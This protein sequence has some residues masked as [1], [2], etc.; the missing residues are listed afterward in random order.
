MS[1]GSIPHLEE[2]NQHV[3]EHLYSLGVRDCALSERLARECVVE[4]CR[5]PGG[6]DKSQL[7]RRSIDEAQRRIDQ[8]LARLCADERSKGVPIE[9]LRAALH[10]DEF[11]TLSVD[12]IV[13]A[14]CL[15]PEMFER[16]ESILRR[17][18]PP[19]APL[20]ME[21]RSFSRGSTA[22]G[23]HECQGEAALPLQ[24]ASRGTT[25]LR[26]WVIFAFASG[27]TILA[28]VTVAR[29]MFAIGL[30]DTGLALL[31]IYTLLFST[32]A[33]SFWTAM[34]GLLVR[35]S[36]GDTKS[37]GRSLPRA[38]GK[39]ELS[40]FQ[41]RTALLM[42]IHNEDPIRVFAG[43]RAT[44]DSLR[45][46]GRSDEFEVFILS[47][48]QDSEIYA[49][50]E[51]HWHR[52]CR[53]FE[54]YGRIF[55][56]R[57][58]HNSGRKSGNVEEFCQ[59]WGGRYRYMV[60]MDADS[61]MSGACIT[62]LLDMIEAHPQVALIQ[63][64]PIAIGQK[65]LFARIIQF[66][67]SVLSPLYT[68]G[69]AWWFRGGSNY[70][71]HN[72][73]VRV[74]PFA[75]HCG[76]PRLPGREPLGGEIL[77]HDFVEAALLRNAGWEVWLVN[78]VAGSYEQVPPTLIDYVKR[79]R[80]WCQGNL[81]H[82]RVLLAQ[83]FASL[84]RL[85]LLMGIM[86]YVSSPLWLLFLFLGTMELSREVQLMVT[87]EEFQRASTDLRSMF[88]L[89]LAMLFLPRLGG[90]LNCY[91]DPSQMRSRGGYFRFTLS[92]FLEVLVAIAIAPVLMLY[93]C[94]FVCET[95][96]GRSV[97]W[98]GQAR[99]GHLTSLKKATAAHGLHTILGVVGAIVIYVYI[100]QVLWWTSPVLVGLVIS[101]V[102]SSV[103]S[104]E[105]LGKRARNLRLFLI[106][107]ETC[108]PRVIIHRRE[109]LAQLT[110][111]S[112]ATRPSVDSEF[113]DHSQT[114]RFVTGFSNATN[115]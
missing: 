29:A 100:P 94:R 9:Q 78:E 15:R 14:V 56:R 113:G 60:V 73:I 35:L 86:N 31:V 104:S 10:L 34:I 12:E 8:A 27:T 87:P 91:L 112:N 52:M 36:G 79:E 109:H 32:L 88:W 77:S 93:H 90:L 105:V 21:K 5:C 45:E 108:S 33:L 72:A 95:L 67:S 2:L 7:R 74:S 18:T 38:T 65:T 102:T 83:K 59:R 107:E 84:S 63:S 40:S 22:A 75:Q 66:G 26:R 64:T 62:T 11:E 68:T 28:V 1:Q 17:P 58:K 106:A 92:L 89:T 99:D 4:A 43:L 46:T 23:E 85:H 51:A 50:E 49:Q 114:P 61:I 103:T 96:V 70:W 115:Q 20:A 53:D 39:I 98:S 97:K 82:I 19:E 69:S 76:L 101:I 41:T 55:Y 37:I 3:A 81:Q 16:L 24:S 6:S 80:R 57:R 110:S 25:L 42:P 47:D 48:T 54:A 30:S 111:K 13:E 71:G 44:F